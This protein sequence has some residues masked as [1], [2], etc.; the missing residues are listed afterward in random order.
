[1]SE[2][3]VVAVEGPA[4]RLLVRGLAELEPALARLADSALLI[5]GL[6]TKLWL[7][8]RPIDV[9]ARAT[10]DVDLGID[11]RGLGLTGDRKLVEPLLRDLDFHHR[12]GDDEFRF[13][14]EI[15]GNA[16]VV[17]LLVPSGRS[18]ERPPELESGLPS[19]AAPGLAY[20][21]ARG[22]VLFE[23]E[24]VDGDESRRFELQLP[25]LDAAFVLKAALLQRGLRMRRDRR[26]ADTVDGV[27]LAAA[28]IR[29]ESALAALRENRRQSEVRDALRWI[30]TALPTDR[31]DAATRVQRHF[32]EEAGID[33]GAEWA[34]GVAVRFVRAIE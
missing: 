3:V 31:S 9:P 22:A 8:A 19:L 29:D 1:M 16:F 20:A 7:H 21:H 15:D 11:R 34:V 4:D 14:K 2:R 25:T 10:A 33:T 18:R 23:A 32:E 28:C 17:D 30:G 13:T 12:A 5:G 27:S 6:M 26:T 24:F